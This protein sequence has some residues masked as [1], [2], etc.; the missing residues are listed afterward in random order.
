MFYFSIHGRGFAP[1][2]KA[3][4]SLDGFQKIAANEGNLCVLLDCCG[5]READT[6]AKEFDLC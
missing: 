2:D 1:G 3:K 4:A 5:K 6:R